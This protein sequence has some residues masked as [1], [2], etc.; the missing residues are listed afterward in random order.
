MFD[1]LKHLSSL[2]LWDSAI[3]PIRLL[4]R[5]DSV[6]NDLPGKKGEIAKRTQFH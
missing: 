3:G 2:A 5:H 4:N 6:G 1:V